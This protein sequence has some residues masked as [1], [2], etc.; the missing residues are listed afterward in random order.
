MTNY[1]NPPFFMNWPWAQL[2]PHY[3]PETSQTLELGGRIYQYF[4]VALH[5]PQ[6]EQMMSP[7]GPQSMPQ[8]LPPLMLGQPLAGP[9]STYEEAE[10]WSKKLLLGTESIVVPLPTSLFGRR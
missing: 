4:L 5:R 10:E 2:A 9:F 1:Q 8:Q 7:F 6:A 3:R